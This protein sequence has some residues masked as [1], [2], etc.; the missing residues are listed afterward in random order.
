MLC[1]QALAQSMKAG[2][3]RVC[4]QIDSP[5]KTDSLELII[6]SISS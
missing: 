5:G 3:Q 1:L 6:V 2:G 4:L